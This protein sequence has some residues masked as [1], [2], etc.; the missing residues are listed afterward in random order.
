M[1]QVYYHHLHSTRAAQEDEKG[2]EKPIL[3]KAG[4]EG[5]KGSEELATARRHARQEVEAILDLVGNDTSFCV[6]SR[7][8]KTVVENKLLS[9]LFTLYNG[10]NGGQSMTH[11][12]EVLLDCV[13][14]EAGELIMVPNS[15][16][17]AEITNLDSPE[18]Q[19][20]KNCLETLRLP[21][22]SDF[23]SAL[24]A[25]H[26]WGCEK[27]AIV[28]QLYAPCLGA[29][30]EL[31]P[32]SDPWMWSNLLSTIL[33]MVQS[34]V[35]A[36]LFINAE[37]Q[38][39]DV[40]AHK[41][42]RATILANIL[43]FPPHRS[44]EGELENESVAEKILTR[45]REEDFAA[46]LRWFREV[47]SKKASEAVDGEKKAVGD[48]CCSAD[49]SLNA[50]LIM[51]S[52]CSTATEDFKDYASL[53]QK[54][55]PKFCDS[56]SEGKKSL[57]QFGI[58]TQ[59]FFLTHFYMS[60][61]F[62]R[63]NDA[64]GPISYDQ[65]EIYSHYCE[66]LFSQK[67]MSQLNGFLAFTSFLLMNRI[68]P[69]NRFETYLLSD[70]PVHAPKEFAELPEYMIENVHNGLA[71]YLKS[72]RSDFITLNKCAL[73]RFAARLCS[74]LLYMPYVRSPSI[75]EKL[76]ESFGLLIDNLWENYKT[77]MLLR[78]ERDELFVS[79]LMP[80]VI[81]SFIFV[82]TLKDSEEKLQ[83]C[84]GLLKTFRH[85]WNKENSAAEGEW[86]D[87]VEKEAEETARFLDALVDNFYQV[88]IK[89]T[90]EFQQK[91]GEKTRAKEAQTKFLGSLLAAQLGTISDLSYVARGMLAKSPTFARSLNFC[92]KYLT[93]I[94][95]S[96][97]RS[98]GKNMDAYGFGDKVMLPRLVEIYGNCRN[99]PDFP[100][101]LCGED[102]ER[103]MEMFQAVIDR[104]LTG[105]LCAAPEALV[106][107][108]ELWGKIKA[109]SM[110]AP[111]YRREDKIDNDA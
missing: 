4:D 85:A 13:L 50:F 107:F 91:M 2:H 1:N 87:L 60:L 109:I 28:R 82:H 43:R 73:A 51:L 25:D 68:L 75:R 98:G 7:K 76:A 44:S 3:S 63:L 70:F 58:E 66:P 18:A 106:R 31:E 86:K 83:A 67:S 27:E 71:L 37:L 78:V 95:E 11:D 110:V 45:L 74:A 40:A 38:S 23:F 100:E 26:F 35:G 20:Y 6:F 65:I 49:F 16:Y 39:P 102:A 56:V 14:S 90:D 84:S 55:Q 59:T 34:P 30:L 64:V 96:D 103:V 61:F 88:C 94:R 19:P 54:L 10:I 104:H 80:I 101:N 53:S 33:A 24:L 9:Y 69:M 62:D 32:E 92:L 12:A 46:V 72:G 77:D 21:D 48:K 108:Q 8:V 15:Y 41:V 93:I 89:L 99:Q 57:V 52:F 105:N 79:Q 36:K 42:E 5:A 81:R 97:V 111:V 17:A 29:I 47:A 22:S